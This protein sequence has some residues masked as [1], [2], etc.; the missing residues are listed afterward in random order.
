MKILL[1]HNAYQQAGG[2]DVVFESEKRTLERAG[3]RVISYVRSNEELQ[4]APLLDRISIAP[5]MIWS[6]AT[7]SLA[8]RIFTYQIDPPVQLRANLA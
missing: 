4:N 2:E 7:Q 1:V 6:S 5:R 8:C 3:H